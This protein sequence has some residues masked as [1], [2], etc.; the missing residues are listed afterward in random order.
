MRSSSI[1]KSI[2]FLVGIMCGS[3]LTLHISSLLGIF[4]SPCCSDIESELGHIVPMNYVLENST[5]SNSNKKCNNDNDDL[6]D[7]VKM[8]RQWVAK[9]EREKLE[10]CKEVDYSK[11]NTGTGT[12][13]ILDGDGGI[14]NEEHNPTAYLQVDSLP[15]Q[16]GGKKIHSEDSVCRGMPL[17]LPSSETIWMENIG[18]IFR[19]SKHRRD[20]DWNFKEFTTLLMNLLPPSTLRKSIKT[21][22]SQDAMRNILG[23]VQKRRDYFASHDVQKD[24]NNAPPPLKVLVMGG[25]VTM[26][27]MC[28]DNPE[29]IKAGR[30]FRCK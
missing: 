25:S 11:Q 19:Q 21:P 2:L 13:T 18:A 29:N 26:G 14:N 17:A 24:D 5:S 9:L 7:K 4:C 20:P 3:L 27:V 16:P 12:G 22:P 23:I 15:I 6:V 1:N 8:L 28:R 10:K 30:F